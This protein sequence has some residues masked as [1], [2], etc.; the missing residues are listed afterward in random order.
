MYLNRLSL[1]KLQVDKLALDREVVALLT[2]SQSAAVAA[3]KASLHTEQNLLPNRCM[4]S[5]TC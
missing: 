2:E 3:G 1:K 4:N 5:H